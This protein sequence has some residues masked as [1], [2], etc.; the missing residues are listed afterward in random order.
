MKIDTYQTGV[1]VNDQNNKD[2]SH[3]PTEPDGD[4]VSTFSV[5]GGEHTSV[6]TIL[7][8]ATLRTSDG[9]DLDYCGPS[10]RTHALCLYKWGR[11]WADGHPAL[12][13]WPYVGTDLVPGNMGPSH[14]HFC[15]SHTE[16]SLDDSIS[17]PDVAGKH[18]NSAAH[19]FSTLVDVCVGVGPR[20]APGLFGLQG[21]AET[22]S[23][24]F[25]CIN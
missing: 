23:V 1:Q 18:Q 5:Q 4:A 11:Q 22:T 24:W 20:L 12:S 9:A 8:S 19:L 14:P 16:A 25:F 13:L 3:P 6:Q 15:V 21:G 10:L 7:P 17:P 2:M